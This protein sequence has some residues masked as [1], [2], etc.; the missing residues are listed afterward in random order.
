MEAWRDEL[1]H[2][3]TKGQKWG[4][5]RYQ[6]EDGSLTL[7]GKARYGKP[8]T[9]KEHRQYSDER[10]EAAIS[11]FKTAAKAGVGS[12]GVS[13]LTRGAS[14]AILATGA[15]AAAPLV[16]TVGTVAAVGLSMY[17]TYQGG[18]TIANVIISEVHNKK[19]S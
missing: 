18:K 4:V 1:Y 14:A 17:S 11:S 13:M 12:I 19:A 2:Y 3:G 10:K 8:M 6:N 7:A 9:K 15:A 5:R 16:A